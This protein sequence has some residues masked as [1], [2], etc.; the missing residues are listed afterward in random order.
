MIM[1]Q[2]VRQFEKTNVLPFRVKSFKIPAAEFEKIYKHLESA[3]WIINQ[4]MPLD[5]EDRDAACRQLSDALCALR[6]L[7]AKGEMQP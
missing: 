6:E 1:T 5:W 2:P 7:R 4:D 3:A